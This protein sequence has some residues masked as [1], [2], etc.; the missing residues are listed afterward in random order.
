MNE[1]FTKMAENM[2]PDFE[3]AA[4]RVRDL[5]EKIIEAARNNG[6]ASLDF[7]E[8]TL[9]DVLQFSQQAADATQVDLIKA[10][11]TAHVN[12][13]TDVTKAWTNAARDIL[14]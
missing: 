6:T 8:K 14:K 13:I 10:I 12:Y 5:N 11:T 9:T 4:G 7:Y 3:Q 1:E 2:T